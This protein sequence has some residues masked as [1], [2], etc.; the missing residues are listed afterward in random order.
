MREVVTW[1]GH[2]CRVG[3]TPVNLP[4]TDLALCPKSLSVPVVPVEAPS[5]PSYAAPSTSFFLAALRPME[6]PGHR[7]DLSTSRN[8]C[9]TCGNTGSLTHCAR[10][11]M[12][13][14]SLAL[15]R[16]HH[17]CCHHSGGS[18]FHL[19]WSCSSAVG[20]PSKFS[21]SNP[22]PSCPFHLGP[23]PWPGM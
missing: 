23:R 10:Q 3:A 18:P 11:G 21:S 1:R 15:Q 7:S 13:P 12:E 17:S 19:S 20:P 14:A 16:H 22:K 8:L 2:I 5:R 4:A 9:C 6:F